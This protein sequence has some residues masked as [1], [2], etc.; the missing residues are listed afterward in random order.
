MTPS[1]GDSLRHWTQSVKK[2]NHVSHCIYLLLSH[3]SIVSQAVEQST[4]YLLSCHHSRFNSLLTRNKRKFKT[5]PLARR[6]E[7]HPQWIWIWSTGRDTQEDQPYTLP[8]SRAKFHCAKCHCSLRPMMGNVRC[9]ISL[10]LALFTISYFTA[11]CALSGCQNKSQWNQQLCHSH[12]EIRWTA[13]DLL[14]FQQAYSERL[15]TP[16]FLP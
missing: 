1:S 3:F 15:Q 6:K 4:T 7:S 10:S 5:P 12:S 13:C 8:L 14:L 9:G 2:V 11:C 16:H